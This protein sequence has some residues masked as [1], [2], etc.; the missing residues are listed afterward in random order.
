MNQALNLKSASA[1]S[2]ENER[3]IH[4]VVSA[5]LTPTQKGECRCHWLDP[6]KTRILAWKSTKDP[7]TLVLK[8][9]DQKFIGL[10]RHDKNSEMYWKFKDFYETASPVG[11]PV[12]ETPPLVEKE[13]TKEPEPKI[14]LPNQESSD[15]V[16]K[17]REKYGT[18][19]NP[20]R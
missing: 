19:D 14:N 5:L 3:L 13:P 7:D 18:V 20:S 2:P 9:A 1:I 17:F 4:Q 12:V 8:I 15:H 10:V 11:N 6:N 16:A